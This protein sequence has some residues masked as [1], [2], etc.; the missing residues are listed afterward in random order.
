M[1]F[2][3]IK[4]Y[5]YNEIANNHTFVWLTKN[6]VEINYGKRGTL[7]T[8][9]SQTEFGSIMLK[10]S[11]CDYRDEKIIFKKSITIVGWREGIAADEN[12][13]ALPVTWL[14][15]RSNWTIEKLK[16]YAQ[17]TRCI[18]EINSAQ[19]YNVKDLVVLKPMHRKQW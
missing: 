9:D 7:D 12:E 18:S 8:G 14:P 5:K 16:I 17:F 15:K 2:R 3:L 4:I 11:F 1:E 6:W 19:V 13:V 10:S